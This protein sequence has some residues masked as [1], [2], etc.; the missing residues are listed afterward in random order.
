MPFFSASATR[1]G[2]NKD[3]RK[4]EMGDRA[5]KRER[6]TLGDVAVE[7]I[8]DDCDVGSHG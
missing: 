6:R 1:G 3:V 5:E 7:G 2:N 4:G 8:D